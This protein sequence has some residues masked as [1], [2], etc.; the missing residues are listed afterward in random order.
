MDYYRGPESAQAIKR[1]SRPLDDRGRDIWGRICEAVNTNGV[2][3]ETFIDW[4]FKE[5]LPGIPFL[6]TLPASF[7]TAFTGCTCKDRVREAVDLHL[8]LMAR[9]LDTLVQQEKYP[10]EDVL[11]D[12]RFEFHCVFSCILGEQLGLTV[13]EKAKKNALYLEE[14]FPHY[15]RAMAERFRGNHSD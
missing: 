9:K 8:N 3:L 6:N 13:P 7:I 10:V 2:D 15:H 11:F 1:M 4:C 14:V 12:E 5:S